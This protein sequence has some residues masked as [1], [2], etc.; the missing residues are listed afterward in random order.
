MATEL[1]PYW[2]LT[3]SLQ[4]T[5]AELIRGEVSKKEARAIAVLV[6]AFEKFEKTELKVERL[7]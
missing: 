3:I 2:K 7:K 5:F 4:R 6:Q 1:S